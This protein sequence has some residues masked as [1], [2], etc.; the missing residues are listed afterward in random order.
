MTAVTPSSQSDD[1]SHRDQSQAKL[2]STTIQE[3]KQKLSNNH[4][5]KISINI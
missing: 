3:I 5:K 1:G 2:T 4:L